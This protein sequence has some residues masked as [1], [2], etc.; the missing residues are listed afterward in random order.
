MQS[1]PSNPKAADSNLTAYAIRESIFAGIIAFGL[2]VLF[3]GLETTQNINNELVVVQH[4][5]KLAVVVVLVMVVRFLMI[6]V[7]RPYFAARKASSLLPTYVAGKA[8]ERFYHFPYAIAAFVIGAALMFLGGPLKSGGSGWIVSLI[9]AVAII[10]FIS[11]IF[12][13]FRAFITRHFALL[14]I[15]ALVLYPI[16]I[17]SLLGFQ[18]ALKYIDNFGIQILI[19]VMLAWG[20]NI[21]VGLAGLLDLGYVAF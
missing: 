14:G 9:Q 3:I 12:Y 11:W 8:A 6:T 18:P 16:V 21:V 19:Y 15:I 5:L 4:W 2:F 1:N 7:I 10:Y 13:V 17:V 20:L